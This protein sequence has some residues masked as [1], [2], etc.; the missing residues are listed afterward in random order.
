[1]DC[2]VQKCYAQVMTTAKGTATRNRIVD[3]AADVLVRGGRE[4]INLD[5]ILAATRTSKSQL[6]H[7]FPGGKQELIRVATERQ[8]ERLAIASAEPLNTFGAWQRWID[9]IIRL[10]RKQTRDDACEV[11]AL[12]G[13]ILDPDPAERNLVGANFS[14]WY[15]HLRTGVEAMKTSGLLQGDA[16][17]PALAALFITSLQGGAVVDKATGSL[18]YLEPALRSALAYLRSFATET[19]SHATV[20]IGGS[21]G[22]R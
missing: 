5:E 12:A 21:R 7:Y 13:R 6:F 22:A 20:K 17:A 18:D 11:A 8:L 4:A 3:A 19:S 1:M 2:Q 16:D 9:G 14:T 15:G 10:H